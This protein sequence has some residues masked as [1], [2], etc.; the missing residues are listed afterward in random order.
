MDAL[1]VVR[2]IVNEAFAKAEKNGE[3]KYV[4]AEATL[5]VFLQNAVEAI[6]KRNAGS[7]FYNL[8]KEY[9]HE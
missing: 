6:D 7:W 2:N 8:L 9:D 1:R 3:S 5:E 4:V